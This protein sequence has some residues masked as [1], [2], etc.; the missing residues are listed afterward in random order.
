M[1]T[2]LPDPASLG[3]RGRNIWVAGTI[4]PLSGTEKGKAGFAGFS[5]LCM[6]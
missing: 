1:L 5:L 4:G 2:H 6:V 3:G